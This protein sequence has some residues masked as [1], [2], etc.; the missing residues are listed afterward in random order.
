MGEGVPKDLALAACWFRRPAHQGHPYAQIHLG[1]SQGHGEAA[2]C[3]AGLLGRMT[4][5]AE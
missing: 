2:A 4:M 1:A 3:L 5:A